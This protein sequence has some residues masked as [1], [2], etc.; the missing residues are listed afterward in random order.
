MNQLL[1]P[2]SLSLGA[3]WWSRGGLDEDKQA[4]WPRLPG[5]LL[6]SAALRAGDSF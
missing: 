1:A 3:C 4:A 6:S 5:D 2:R